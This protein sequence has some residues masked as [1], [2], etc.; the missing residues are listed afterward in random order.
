MFRNRVEDMSIGLQTC[1]IGSVSTRLLCYNPRIARE[2]NR[3]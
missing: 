1:R 3:R 2:G